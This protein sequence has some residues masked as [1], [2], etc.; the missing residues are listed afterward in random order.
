M[1]FITFFDF[2][3]NS[4][5]MP[6]GALCT[7][8]LIGWVIKPKTIADEVTRNKERFRKRDMLEVKKK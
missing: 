3:S 8:I 7:C 6:I 1:D 5:I 2:L 4:I